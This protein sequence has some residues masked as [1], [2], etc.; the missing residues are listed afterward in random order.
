MGYLSFDA[1]VKIHQS[2]RFTSTK[3]DKTGFGGIDGYIRHIDRGTDKKNGCEVN[4]SNPDIDSSCTLD[5]ESYYKDSNG[6]WQETATSKDMRD[7]VNRRIEYAKKHKARIS[8]KGKNDTVIVRPLIVQL[9]NDTIEQHK[10]TWM[11]D[12]M[13]IT[14]KLFGK[15]NIVGFSVHKDETNVHLHIIFVPCYET[16]TCTGETKCTLSQTKFFK[17]PKQL[18]SIHRLYRKE[19]CDQYYDIELE[20]KPIEEHLAGY[21]DSNGVWHQ[22]G[23][24]PDQMKELSSK[25]LNLQIGELNMKLRQ[26]EMDKLEQAMKQMQEAAKSNQAQLEKDR[27]EL[28]T[29]QALLDN[30]KASV[31]AQMQMILNETVSV[32]QLKKEAAE[33]MAKS[34][35]MSD[36]C[37][38]IINDEKNLNAKF[39]EFLDK[40][41][42][43]TKKPLRKLVESL[44]KKFQNERK[45]NLSSWNLEMLRVREERKKKGYTNSPELNIIDTDSS[46]TDYDLTM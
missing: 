14:E 17:N 32:E 18:A 45:A 11:W 30:Q 42:E 7:A 43:R 38:Q 10:E 15:E 6:V 28:D 9:D 36:V 16:K 33:M 8:D 40:E 1:S 34:Y 26:E 41:S 24:T 3:T 27:A 13:E 25:M 44:Y 22:Q 19:L 29:Q 35:S 46:I 12:V 37:T 39:L 23:L 2:G 31:Q 5:N 21:T 4:H 20:N